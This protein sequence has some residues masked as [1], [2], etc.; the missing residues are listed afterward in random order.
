MIVAERKPIAELT[1]RLA[2]YRRILVVG[3]NTCVAVCSAGG[4]KEVA[5]T[6]AL[7]RIALGREHPETRVD[8]TC[9]E[10]QCEVEMNAELAPSLGNYEVI[11]SMACGVGVQTL[12]EQFNTAVVIPALNTKFMGRPEG[13]GEWS[14]RCAGCGNCVL[15]RYAGVC[16]ITR[17]SKNLLNGP[18]GG[19]ANGRCEVDPERLPC[20]WQLIYDRWVAL[21]Q[22]DRYLTNEPA[23][24]WSSSLHGGPRRIQREDIR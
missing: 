24:D 20:A 18:C 1:S 21:G 16:P 19:S 6:S 2:P 11:L 5:V 22:L 14:E 10:R 13:L 23:K 12:A 17:C 3:C 9:V 15:E 4:A 8:E 7:L